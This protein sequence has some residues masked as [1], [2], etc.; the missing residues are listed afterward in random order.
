VKNNFEVGNAQGNRIST[1]ENGKQVV[2]VPAS[3]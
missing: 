3:L 1:F 2:I